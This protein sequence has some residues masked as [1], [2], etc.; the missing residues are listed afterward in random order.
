MLLALNTYGILLTLKSEIGAGYGVMGWLENFRNS[1]KKVGLKMP[2]NK[3]KHI[4][5]AK[6]Q[7]KERTIKYRQKLKMRFRVLLQLK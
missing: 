6:Y 2:H 3:T 5:T 1:N 4:L 7:R